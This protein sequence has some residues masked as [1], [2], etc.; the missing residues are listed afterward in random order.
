MEDKESLEER[1]IT[2][3]HRYAE[4][5]SEASCRCIIVAGL[6]VD[7]KALLE[8]EMLKANIIVA[9][10]AEEDIKRAVPPTISMPELK[11]LTIS[12]YYVAEKKRDKKKGWQR[13]YKYHK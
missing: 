11:T 13:P 8:A 2:I 12:D 6:G 9:L 3:D 10:A 1:G 4:L 7:K 5:L